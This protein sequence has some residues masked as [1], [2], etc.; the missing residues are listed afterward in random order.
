MFCL[1]RPISRFTFCLTSETIRVRIR[2]NLNS[3]E[4]DIH[5]VSTRKVI[6]Q[7]VG[8]LL[9]GTSEHDEVWFKLSGIKKELNW[10]QRAFVK[11]NIAN[12]DV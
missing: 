9:F 2:K 4:Y 8:Q 5:V 11:R 6:S 1:K 10:F 12:C 3:V 7:L